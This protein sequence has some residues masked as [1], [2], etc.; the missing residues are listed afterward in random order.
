MCCKTDTEME[1]QH[2]DLLI[3]KRTYL[4]E[5]LDMSLLMDHMVQTYLLS[6]SDK[7]ILEVNYF[8]PVLIL[9]LVTHWKH[10][11]I[12]PIIIS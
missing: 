12:V 5:N 10:V 7:E 6:D 2:E 3:S 4:V 1:K 8:I 11:L 9:Y